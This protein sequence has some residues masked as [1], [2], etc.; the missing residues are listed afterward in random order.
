[1]ICRFPS[2]VS[3]K[4]GVAGVLRKQTCFE[5]KSKVTWTSQIALS[6]ERKMENHINKHLKHQN[7]GGNQ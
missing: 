5:I 3:G 6:L 4:D 7:V 1:M 2:T